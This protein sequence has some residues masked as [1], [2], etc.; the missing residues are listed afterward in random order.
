MKVRFAWQRPRVINVI[1][2]RPLQQSIFISGSKTTLVL[3]SSLIHSFT[4][5]PDANKHPLTVALRVPR[6]NN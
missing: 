5:F 1:S 3:P 6:A 4:G 2:W